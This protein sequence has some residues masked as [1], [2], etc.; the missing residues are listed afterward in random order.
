MFSLGGVDQTHTH[1]SQY[2]RSGVNV[3]S[4]DIA[5]ILTVEKNA[6][7]MPSRCDN[8]RQSICI[9]RMPDKNE[10]ETERSFH[11]DGDT[12][13]MR[14]QLGAIMVISQTLLVF[15]ISVPMKDPRINRPVGETRSPDLNESNSTPHLYECFAVLSEILDRIHER[16]T[17]FSYTAQTERALSKHNTDATS[18]NNKRRGLQCEN[19]RM[20]GER[21]KRIFFLFLIWRNRSRFFSRLSLGGLVFKLS[22]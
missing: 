15:S 7:P 13:R 22:K 10:T 17:S 2:E 21:S 20:I 3:Y 9:L 5:A 16:I 11:Y 6:T 1:L 14:P 8:V 4:C 12:L 18:F 19:M